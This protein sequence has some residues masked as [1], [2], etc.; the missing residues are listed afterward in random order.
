MKIERDK[1]EG[2]RRVA[3]DGCYLMG[4]I[5]VV[6]TGAG[7]GIGAALA[8]HLARAARGRLALVARR[9]DALEA[10]AKSRGGVLLDPR[11]RFVREFVWPALAGPIQGREK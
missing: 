8:G 4:E 1:I 2:D 10:V 9:Q 6:I 11:H 5:V 7:S 3:I